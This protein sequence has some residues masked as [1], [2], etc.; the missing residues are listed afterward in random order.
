MDRNEKLYENRQI[1]R[2]VLGPGRHF[3]IMIIDKVSRKGKKGDSHDGKETDRPHVQRGIQRAQSL[4]GAL[5]FPAAYNKWLEQDDYYDN[6]KR[7]RP[8]YRL[9]VRSGLAARLAPIAPRMASEEELLYFH[10]PAYLE[11]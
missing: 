6:P 8:T 1:P 11:N 5:L 10:T 4:R 2:A 9:L 7:L 3:S